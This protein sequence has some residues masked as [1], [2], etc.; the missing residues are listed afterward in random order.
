M[1]N[2]IGN[3]MLPNKMPRKP[4]CC[5]LADLITRMP[6]IFTA[7]LIFS[8]RN[9]ARRSTYLTTFYCGLKIHLLESHYQMLHPYQKNREIEM[10]QLVVILFPAFK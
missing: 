1:P 8:F 7:D 5:L 6:L 4:H 3:T 2:T 10:A 9:S